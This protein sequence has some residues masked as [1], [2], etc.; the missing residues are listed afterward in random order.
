MAQA[1]SLFSQQN[2]PAAGGSSLFSGQVQAPI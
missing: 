1:N 2:M